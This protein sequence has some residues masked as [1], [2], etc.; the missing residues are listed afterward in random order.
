M[1]IGKKFLKYAIPSVVSM[2]VF[3]I[4]TMVDGI[5]VSNGV[6]ELALAAVNISVPFVNVLFG[7]AL[8]FTVGTST[9]VSVAMGKGDHDEANR[10]FSLNFYVLAVLSVIITLFG[11]L[12]L[13][14]IAHFLGANAETLDYVKSYLGILI[15][16][17]IF[18]ILSYCLEVLVKTDG[19]PVLATACMCLGAITNIGLDYIFVIKLNWG[20]NGA[21]WATGIAQVTSFVIFFIHFMGKKSNLKFVKVKPDLSVYKIIIPLGLP[22]CIMEVSSGVTV[23]MYNIV[24]VKLIGNSGVVIYTIISYIFNLVLMTM[25]GISQGIQPLISY[26]LGENNYKNIKKLYKMGIFSAFISGMVLF[27]VFRIFSRGIINIFISG[28]SDEFISYAVKALKIFSYCF[29]VIGFNVI[30]LGFFTA[31]EKPKYSFIISSL[32]GFILIPVGIALTVLIGGKDMVWLGVAVS[33]SIC[34]VF[35]FILKNRYLKA[36]HFSNIKGT[37]LK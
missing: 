13:D 23:F 34:A 12:N 36:S 25:A 5:F 11:I 33:E 6:S 4:Y 15:S 8:W 19:F 32:R 17:S 26:A 10:V 1:S 29:L 7:L 31:V 28:E 21:A 9:L 30:T 3:T 27:L 24:L 18:Y 16:F 37:G 20:I 35:T 14:S 2:W 22:D